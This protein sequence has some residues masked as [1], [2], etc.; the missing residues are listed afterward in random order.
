MLKNIAAFT[1]TDGYAPPFIS[2]NES[3][4]TRAVVVTVREAPPPKG[5]GKIAEINL[6]RAEFE[7][8]MADAR[9]KGF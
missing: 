6:T 7:N 9:A 8:L 2:I 3:A 1:A 5:S 4:E